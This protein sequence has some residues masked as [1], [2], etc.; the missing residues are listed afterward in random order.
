[1]TPDD[2]RLIFAA[3]AGIAVSILLIVRGRL[4]P[5]IALLC[6]AFLVGLLA[7]LSPADTAKAVQKGAGDVL[8]GTGLVVA[9][10]LSLGAMLQLSGGAAALANAGLRLTGS[11]RAPWASVGIG[12]LIGLPLF[13][14]TG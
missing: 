3:L 10:G 6:G 12:L 4:H 2:I 9:L 8:G 1:M 14:E 13:F 11:E 7:G 5:F